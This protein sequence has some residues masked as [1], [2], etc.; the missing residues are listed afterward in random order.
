MISEK[1]FLFE[2]NFHRIIVQNNE[3]SFFFFFF[4]NKNRDE[5][6]I[7][8]VKI[9]MQFCIIDSFMMMM[10]LKREKKFLGENF[11]KII[12]QNNEY[13]F[14]FLIKIGMKSLVIVKINV[15]FCVIDSFTVMMI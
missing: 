12:V 10:I 7:V 15:R 3:Y 11:H 14:F 8:I 5:I 13:S 1:R 6:S 9:N 2:E 4:F